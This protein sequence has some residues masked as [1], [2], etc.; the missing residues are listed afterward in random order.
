[1]MGSSVAYLYSVALL[2]VPA[3][4][5]HVYFETSAVIITLIKLGKLLEARAKGQTGEAIRK[6]MG[7][8]PKTA[9]VE[10]DGEEID[11]PVEQVRVGDLVVV[12]PGERLPVDGVVIHGHSAV[13]ES[14]LTG[15]PLP[16]DKGPGDEVI[17]A[18]INKQG[19]LKF[20]ATRIG[21][22]TALSQIIRL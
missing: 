22:E 9:R 13:D 7:L 10:R 18:T 12:R 11:V 20:E 16:V 6:L 17:G 8:R 5:Q 14:M 3:V 15:E 21:A 4:G 1:A 2:L 19:R